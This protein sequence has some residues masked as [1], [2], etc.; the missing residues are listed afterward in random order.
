MKTILTII[1]CSFLLTNSASAQEVEKNL[2]DAR[3]AY[4]SGDLEAARF[5]LQQAMY[6]LDLAIGREILKLLPAQLG[7][8]SFN[9]TDDEVGSAN[10]GFI[11]LH[12]SRTYQ[13]DDKQTAQLQI[14]ADSPL[15]AGINAILAMPVIGRDPNQKRIRVDGYR[16]L[17]QKSESSDGI[18][19]WDMQ[20]PFGSSLL[21]VSFKDIEEESTV[22]DMA[23]TIPI[24]QIARLIQ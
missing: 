2:N 15:L 22:M 13:N 18:T 24:Q 6:E 17:L 19:S 3:S 14:I 20:I 11:G 21:T 8:L 16:G 7:M 23:N 4:N 9:E 1:F 12:L 10:M 5:A